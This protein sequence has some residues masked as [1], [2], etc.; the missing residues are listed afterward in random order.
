MKAWPKAALGD[1]ISRTDENAVLD[2]IPA[3]RRPPITLLFE[4]QTMNNP[5][6]TSMTE[7]TRDRHL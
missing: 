3:L 6:F 2:P 1:L 7:S 5:F 4:I